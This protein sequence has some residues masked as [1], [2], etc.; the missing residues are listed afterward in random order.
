MALGFVFHQ[1]RHEGLIKRA[2]CKQATKKIGDTKGDEEKIR[3][4][5]CAKEIGEND[6]AHQSA[7]T[8]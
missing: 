2:F 7:N 1:Y 4:S 5:R 6:V 3:G 8:R